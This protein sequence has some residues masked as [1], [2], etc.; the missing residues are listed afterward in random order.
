[1]LTERE[2]TMERLRNQARIYVRPRQHLEPAPV[3]SRPIEHELPPMVLAGQNRRAAASPTLQRETT[4]ASLP[5]THSRRWN[6]H[7]GK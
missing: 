3:L 5:L 1:M 7:R 2:S 6:P 4:A